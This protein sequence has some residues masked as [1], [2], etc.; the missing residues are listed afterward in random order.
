[1]VNPRHQTP[2]GQS[3]AKPGTPLWKILVG[4]VRMNTKESDGNMF[5][6]IF[7]ENAQGQ[8]HQRSCVFAKSELLSYR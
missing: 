6:P 7:K 2:Q 3:V 8:K 5:N 4:N 1:M